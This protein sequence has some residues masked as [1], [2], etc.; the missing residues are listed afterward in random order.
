[1]TLLHIRKPRKRKKSDNQNVSSTPTV[2]AYLVPTS[3]GLV[4]AC[5]PQLLNVL[6]IFCIYYIHDLRKGP[7]NNHLISDY[8]LWIQSIQP[9][10]G[11]Y[12]LLFF[13]LGNTLV[14]RKCGPGW[15]RIKVQ[16]RILIC[17]DISLP[18]YREQDETQ[19]HAH[20]VTSKEHRIPFP[21][22]MLFL[23]K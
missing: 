1:M 9:H 15:T 17:W 23:K 13:H 5:F 10:H 12:I 4:L 3:L 6:L 7:E 8:S 21:Y 19:S 16:T 20:R 14:H 22:T 18:L 11:A 2:L